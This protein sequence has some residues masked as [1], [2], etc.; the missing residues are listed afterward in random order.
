LIVNEKYEGI[1]MYNNTDPESPEYVGFISIPGNLD[2][3]IKDDIM[4]ADSYVDLLTIDVSDLKDP[5]FV[6]REEEVFN[7]YRFWETLGYFVYT[8]E[9]QRTLELS[10]DDPNFNEP[11]FWQGGNV[12]ANE[13]LDFDSS[14]P[15]SI[16]S[17]SGSSSITGQG[18]SFAR[19]SVLGDHLYVLNDSE[20]KSFSI[21]DQNA[22][23]QLS[24][25]SVDWGRIETLFPYGNYLFIGGTQGMYIYDRT[26]PDEPA[27]VSRFTHA[28]A[29]DPVVVQG[30]TAYV[31]LRNGSRCESF[32]N[33]LDI[34]DISNIEN[35]QL[36]KTYDMTNPHGLAVVNDE[37]YICDGDAGLRVFDKSDLNKID[38]NQVDHINDINAYDIIPLSR[39]HVIVVGDGG[40]YQYDSSDPKKLKQLSFISISK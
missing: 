13:S 40:L 24:S 29:C 39:E 22:P 26:N 33:Q 35:P 5:K 34:V 7:I 38:D 8:K 4:Y 17:G 28:R 18:G 1:H 21:E 30:N 31:T 19:F 10:C 23:E 15:T 20:L 36:Q 6:T 25:V 32:T 37:L 3:S 14:L 2:V 27:F 9:T 11:W 12:F 16:N